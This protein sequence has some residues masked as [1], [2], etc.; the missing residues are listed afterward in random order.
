MLNRTGDKLHLHRFNLKDRLEKAGT[1]YLVVA[2]RPPALARRGVKFSVRPE[3]LSKKGG[4]KLKLEAGP[5][6]MA[7][8]GETVT[9]DVPA[10]AADAEANVILL[11]S[12][13]SGQEVF[14][15]FKLAVRDE[16][17]LPPAARR[18]IGRRR[19]RPRPGRRS[20]TRC[21]TRRRSPR[22]PGS[23]SAR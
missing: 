10:D 16:P 8:D 2:S 15:T 5:D 7:V 13:A 22:G 21:R 6:G 23:R 17:L 20:P 14:H 4:V 19:S 18:R 12:D 9:W 3:V 1:D 11:V